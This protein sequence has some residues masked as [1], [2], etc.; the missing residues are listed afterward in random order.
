[1]C[2]TQR[3]H[4]HLP[5][6]ITAF[7]MLFSSNAWKQ[8]QGKIF[9]SWQLWN[10]SPFPWIKAFLENSNATLSTFFLSMFIFKGNSVF[11]CPLTFA[12][13]KKKAGKIS[14]LMFIKVP[15]LSAFWDRLRCHW[16]A[17]GNPVIYWNDFFFGNGIFYSGKKTNLLIFFNIYRVTKNKFNCFYRNV[18]N[19]QVR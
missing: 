6:E 4:K 10:E 9:C 3:V 2:I 12:A 15:M 7:L 11:S 5:C 18:E 19:D 1:M 14:S 13:N 8:L 16:I 17:R